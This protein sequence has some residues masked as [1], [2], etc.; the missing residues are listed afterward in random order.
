MIA[1]L[2]RGVVG[3]WPEVAA[4]LVAAAWAIGRGRRRR[5]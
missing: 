5:R 1:E 4:V 3:R 2:A